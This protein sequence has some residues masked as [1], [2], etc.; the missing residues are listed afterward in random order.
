[1]ISDQLSLL[2]ANTPSKLGEMNVDVSSFFGS[3]L[4]THG[5]LDHS[6]HDWTI[7]KVDQRLAGTDQKICITFREFPGKPLGLNETNGRRVIALYG[8]DANRWIGQPLLVYRSKTTFAGDI[9]LCVRVCG[10]SQV[11]PDPIFDLQGNPV[12]FQPI[13]PAVPPQPVAPAAPA[14]A[15][16]PVAPVAPAPAA[17]TPW[18]AATQN[19]P[20]T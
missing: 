1:M 11:P 3:K 9:V 13:A 15:P 2:L 8:R 16:A 14:P 7:D 6:W 18:D 12:P 17:A 19:N 4:L 20:S 5:D 10:R